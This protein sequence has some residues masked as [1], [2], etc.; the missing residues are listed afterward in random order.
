MLGKQL[1]RWILDR[2]LGRGGMGQVYLAHAAAPEAAEQQAAIKVL[3]P[4]LARDAGFLQRFVREIDVLRQLDHPNIV[5]FY[6]AGAQDGHFFYAMEYVEGRTFDQ[7]LHDQ[8]RLPWP[9]VLDMALQVC[10]ALK[11]AHDRGIIHRDLKPSNLIRASLE[12]QPLHSYPS[13]PRGERGRS[14]GP[15]VVK[16]TDFGI[17]HVFAGEQLTA[18]GGVVGT[19]EYLSPE[20]AA[21]KPVS[22]RSDLYSLGVVLYTLLAGRTPFEG[23]NVAE[24]LHKHRYGQFERLA[25]LAPDVPHDLEE[26]ISQLL[27][28]DPGRRPAD[29]GVLH[30]QLDS[31]R[32]KFERQGQILATAVSDSPTLTEGPAAAREGPATLMSRLMRQELEQQNRGG[33]IRQFFNHPLVIVTLLLTCIALIAWRFWPSSAESLFHKG[34]A[35]MASEDPDDWERA[36]SEYFEPLQ[37]K[38]PDHPYGKELA[39]YRSQIEEHRAQRAGNRRARDIRLTSEA[40]WFYEEG[41]RFRQQGDEPAAQRR[42]RK[43]AHTF[44]DV[45][46]EQAWVRLAEK[47]LAEPSDR[48]VTGEQRWKSVREAL[49]R[50]RQLRDNGERPRAEEI[51]KGLEELYQDDPSAAGIL[52]EM[53][54]D[55]GT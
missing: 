38:Y 36:W 45:K 53:K 25:R 32:R 10:L 42:W 29:A 46:A 35:L 54:R 19:G 18:T 30:K 39:G 20:Q 3:A 26:I 28:K 13:P 27:E 8:G 11:H 14:E 44:R 47:E 12:D 17:A 51:W 5:R 4:E 43:L 23:D 34:E 24:L 37:A 50:A 31:L 49:T 55:R 2:E 9:D 21:G 7:L 16:L 48:A 33:P 41:L 22:K 52:A 15:G 6:E 40:Q 1:G